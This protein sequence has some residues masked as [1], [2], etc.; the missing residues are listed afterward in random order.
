M[1]DDGGLCIGRL[2]DGEFIGT[3]SCTEQ[4]QL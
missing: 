4:K 2:H 3:R 1:V